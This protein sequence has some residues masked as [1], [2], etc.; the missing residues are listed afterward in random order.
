[1]AAI[2]VIYP[3]YTNL[4]NKDEKF[5]RRMTCSV[6]SLLKNK[7]TFPDFRIIV[8]DSSPTSLKSTLDQILPMD[9]IDYLYRPLQTRIQTGYGRFSKPHTMNVAVKEKV[10]AP[11]VKISDIDIVYSED[12]ME[13]IAFMMERVDVLTYRGHRMHNEFYSSDLNTL[14]KQPGE[15]L[16][17]PGIPTLRTALYH[18]IRGYDEHPEYVGLEDSD[19]LLRLRYMAKANMLQDWEGVTIAHLW[20]VKEWP[21]EQRKKDKE[22]YLARRE[23]LM[24]GQPV[25]VN[26]DG[27]GIGKLY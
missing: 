6:E 14:L 9:L 20:H 1:M 26:P 16:Q 10:T 3:V 7:A 2:D 22:L 5:F 24:S 11:L 12:H 17:T 21:E 13:K 8:S 27:Y 25:E 18:K 23:R 19:F 4:E 15:Y